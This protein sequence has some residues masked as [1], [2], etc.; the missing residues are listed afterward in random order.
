MI[1]FNLL[2]AVKLEFVRAR[3]TRRLAILGSVLFAGVSLITLGLLFANVQLQ[4]KYSRDL[5]KDISSESKKL[6]GVEDISSILT[7][8]NQLKSLSSLHAAKPE[9]E[10]VATYLKQITPADVSI[11]SATID[12]DAQTVKVSGDAKS[13][14]SVN[15]FVDTIKFTTFTTSENTAE[16]NA[17]SEVVLGAV[18]PNGEQGAVSYD[19]TFKFDKTIFSNQT[20]VKLVVPSKVTTRSQLDKP[21][22]VFAP[23]EDQ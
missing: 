2:P 8:Q 17:F 1:Q 22:A 23:K 9:A 18:S 7:V 5:S 10:R 11:S 19:V 21:D 15:S 13:A 14:A 16:T 3:R 12:F 4:A 6:E 20:T